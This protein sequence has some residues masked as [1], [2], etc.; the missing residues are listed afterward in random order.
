[1]NCTGLA[2]DCAVVFY[3]WHCVLIDWLYCID[4]FSCIAASLFNK[5][6]YLLI[7]IANRFESRIGMLYCAPHCWAAEQTADG[8]VTRHDLVHTRRLFTRPFRTRRTVHRILACV[9]LPRF[10]DNVALPAARCRYS[11]RSKS[12]F[13]CSVRG[14]P[15]SRYLFIDTRNADEKDTYSSLFI[16]I[17]RFSEFISNCNLFVVI[18]TVLLRWCL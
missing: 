16:Y 12:P 7:R 2:T 3:E 8:I 13:N 5:L 4:L 1:M 9:Q 11:N 6:T 18:C 15:T 17:L 14:S 10:A